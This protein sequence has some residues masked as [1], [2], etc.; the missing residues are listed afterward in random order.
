MLDRLEYRTE[1]RD[2][3]RAFTRWR[4]ATADPVI[5]VTQQLV[6]VGHAALNA[7]SNG[8][9]SAV[10]EAKASRSDGYT[11]VRTAANVLLGRQTAE[12][13]LQTGQQ[14]DETVHR[15]ALHALETVGHTVQQANVLTSTVKVYVAQK[16]PLKKVI[17]S[18]QQL[19]ALAYNGSGNH[20][21][22]NSD[23][24][25]ATEED[26]MV[27]QLRERRAQQEHENARRSRMA[28]ALLFARSQMNSRKESV[29][30][31]IDHDAVDEGADVED[32]PDEVKSGEDDK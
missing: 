6:Q 2:V 30:D 20:S 21:N 28:H 7:V 18:M 25:S 14:L 31:E 12:T 23:D 15:V 9:K 10:A 11:R 24:D 8:M 13:L 32:A 26:P 29:N 1:S 16:V 5:P 17:K 22:L 27:K 4:A 19:P 3:G